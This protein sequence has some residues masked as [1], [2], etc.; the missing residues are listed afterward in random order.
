MVFR[1]HRQVDEDPGLSNGVEDSIAHDTVSTVETADLEP[2]VNWFIGQTYGEPTT[3][4][5]QPW[6]T[7]R[8]W[9]KVP[10]N[11]EA[12]D[13]RSQFSTLGRLACAATS[14]RGNKHRLQGGVNQDSFSV[15][16]V[17][18]KNGEEYLVVAV[19]DG[20]GS[21]KYSSFAARLAAA[22]C[23]ASL[24][25]GLTLQGLD[26]FSLLEERHV[27]FVS[28]LRESILEYR[29][30][31]Y[32]APPMPA[33]EVDSGEL[34]TTLSFAVIGPAKAEEA[35]AVTGW[36]GDSPVIVVQDGNWHHVSKE[37][38]NGGLHSTASNGLMTTDNLAIRYDNLLPGD[39]LLICTDGVGNFIEY[40]DA[41]TALGR[42]LRSKWSSPPERLEFVRDLSFDI[43]SADDDR[44]AVM[45]WHR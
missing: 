25:R 22:A 17:T 11:G 3:F 21:A 30:G 2:T 23:T 42:D 33:L 20:M 1:N 16:S 27:G 5:S 13:I 4:G 19:C 32:D 15:V 6:H 12:N 10:E 35:L 43:Q 44:T 31:E 38:S 45:I 7:P 24:C 34:Q 8:N 41:E 37:K 26:M 29:V 28:S 40:N 36:I 39:A 14:L 18:A 9:W